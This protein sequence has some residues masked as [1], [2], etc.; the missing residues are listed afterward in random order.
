MVLILDQFEDFLS[1]CT[2]DRQKHFVDY[3]L[4]VI[5]EEAAIVIIV[6]RDEF[7]SLLAKHEKLMKLAEQSLI[8][9]FPPRTKADL[10]NIMSKRISNEGGPQ[11]TSKLS[12]II[13]DVLV[14]I[15]GEHTKHSNPLAHLNH[16][17]SI[18]E[19][20]QETNMVAKENTAL[21]V[22]LSAWAEEIYQHLDGK[23]QALIK[24][25]LMKSISLRDDIR[26]IPDKMHFI[27]INEIC[28]SEFEYDLLEDLIKQ[29]FLITERD[30]YNNGQEMVM[31][32]QS[33]LLYEWLRL[34]EWLN[35]KRQL[36]FWR[37]GFQ[38]QLQA[39]ATSH[40]EV[41]ARSEDRLLSGPELAVAE[42]WL[43]S[44][45]EEFNSEAQLFVEISRQ[46]QEHESLK[47]KAAYEEAQQQRANIEQHHH[48]TLARYLANQSLQAYSQPHTVK[49]GVQLA[50]SALSLY[51]CLEA[52]RAIRQG[53]VLLPRKVRSI[54]A[55][56]PIQ[57]SAFSRNGHYAAVA[58]ENRG[59]IAD[60]KAENDIPAWRFSFTL[61]RDTKV[62]AMTFSS[63]GSYLAVADKNGDLYII[64]LGEKEPRWKKIV[65]G[66]PVSELFFSPDGRYLAVVYQSNQGGMVRI[67]ESP[68]F[69]KSRVYLISGDAY[70]TT[71]TFNE[72][73]NLLA[74]GYADGLAQIHNITHQK[75]IFSREYEYPITALSLSRGVGNI[76][77]ACENREIMV[78]KISSSEQLLHN[79]HDQKIHFIL[80]SPDDRYLVAGGDDSKA[81][82]YEISR[83]GEPKQLSHQGTVYAAT[84]SYDGTYLVTASMD[85]TIQ[86][87]NAKQSFTQWMRFSHS[88]SICN[89]AFSM[90]SHYLFTGDERAIYV[91]DIEKSAQCKTLLRQSAGRVKTSI[92]S[93][94][95]RTTN[96][97]VPSIV[98][99]NAEKPAEI[100]SIEKGYRFDMKYFMNKKVI[101]KIVCSK[102]RKFLAVISDDRYIYLWTPTDEKQPKRL[103]REGNAGYLAFSSDSSLL[104]NWDGNVTVVIWEVSTGRR[105]GRFSFPFPINAVTFHRDNRFLITGDNNGKISIWNWKE[106]SHCFSCS[107]DH[108]SGVSTLELSPGGSR[109]VTVSS[110][111]TVFLWNADGVYLCSLPYEAHS[112]LIQFDVGGQYLAT[113][114]ENKVYLWNVSNGSLHREL[115]LV[116]TVACISIS[117]DREYIATSGNDDN[118]D[119]WD[120]NTGRKI[121]SLRHDTKPTAFVFSLDGKYLA[122]GCSDGTVRIWLWR[123]IDLIHEAMS[124][125]A[126]PLTEEEWQQFAGDEPYQIISDLLNQYNW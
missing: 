94:A 32:A 11:D 113:T 7:Y 35:E 99:A 36:L 19:Q 53:L 1:Q 43:K 108:S 79:Q 72:G 78:T 66:L 47:L 86:I 73:G 13:D 82:V 69:S 39:W 118:V 90:E 98:V 115:S 24:H 18:E 93:L 106:K 63:E 8:N 122:T 126:Y 77:V 74:I 29:K 17:L 67:L 96:I 97:N 40:L 30:R 44:W 3:L 88:E 54:P 12:Q 105:I 37:Q 55:D 123:P 2:L 80:F 59:L 28:R 41:E 116:S 104:A 112:S 56:F 42:Q 45:P 33:E 92:A 15:E 51:P 31:L 22:S 102:D 14:T 100:W 6:L 62:V 83:K 4:K 65:Y 23:G 85:R 103:R 87:W 68:S 21:S 16:Y 60:L 121:A 107:P 26:G 109:L 111:G 52:D 81:R 101:K 46:K 125:I 48:K 10:L 114:Y 38:R 9:V 91:W 57:V 89:L 70:V 76:A 84:F 5:S 117:P 20:Y 75:M 71:I 58:H 27:S 50:A 49:Q 110:D 95:W 119:I 34:R 120:I 64:P 124:R 61:D 25:L